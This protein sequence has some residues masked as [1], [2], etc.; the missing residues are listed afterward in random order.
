M[1]DEYTSETDANAIDREAQKIADD[2]EAL[3]M[4]H[5]RIQ[6]LYL[7]ESPMRAIYNTR[8]MV[9]YSRHPLDLPESML[10][11]A[12]V[13]RTQYLSLK[14]RVAKTL[15]MNEDGVQFMVSDY[16]TGIKAETDR[17]NVESW[18][19]GMHESMRELFPTIE[20][21][22]VDDLLVHSRTGVIVLPRVEA[23][24]GAPAPDFEKVNSLDDDAIDEIEREINQK[25]EERE[26]YIAAHSPFYWRHIPSEALIESRNVR[27][28]LHEVVIVEEMAC[29]DVLREWPN[30]ESNL[31]A[32]DR[33]VLT[34]DDTVTVVH[35][36]TD[37]ICEIAII[38]QQITR[39]E[40]DRQTSRTG[41]VM[42]EQMLY[43]DK[44]EMRCVPVA[45]A[46]GETNATRDPGKRFVGFFDNAISATWFLDNLITQAG[47]IVRGTAY[48]TPVV[49]KH[50]EAPLSQVGEEST[51]RVMELIEGAVND[52]LQRGETLKPFNMMDTGTFQTI[53]DLTQFIQNLVDMQTL[54]A[55][56]NGISGA[57]SGY[58]LGLEQAQVE[59]PL[60]HWQWGAQWLWVQVARLQLKAACVMMRAGLDPIPVRYVSS[61]GTQQ[62]KLT[63]DQAEKDWHFRTQVRIRQ[64]GGEMAMVQTLQAAEQA[65]YI[66]HFDAM[67]RFGVRNPSQKWEEIQIQQHANSPMIFQALDQALS[68]DTVAALTNPEVGQMQGAPI[69]PDS[70]AALIQTPGALARLPQGMGA[71]GATPTAGFGAQ[72][73]LP[74]MAGINM[75]PPPPTLSQGA[76]A[77]AAAG[78]PTGPTFGQGQASP[79]GIMRQ[80]AIA[81]A[82]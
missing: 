13:I 38:D 45:I 68:R 26:E 49:E 43:R 47:S 46:Y 41:S 79:G 17:S 25:R 48:P 39:V 3:A 12:A 24:K 60:L 9:L 65:G 74:N 71:M 37:T 54:P 51:P 44:H 58:Q 55:Q 78:M 22:I 56:A 42:S 14:R 30:A 2:A 53:K 40:G 62:V 82:T 75:A 35:R 28:G 10:E 77:Q 7:A 34:D 69:I 29:L 73:G 31:A 67:S 33:L 72:G 52:I 1:A 32:I 57:E 15:L 11:R 61:N 66:D 23:M 8:N 20:S 27:G 18:T 4:L 63:L 81:G 80:S 76:Q 59:R 70:L 5:D 64:V 21:D 16:G 50:I 36:L 6:A 19:Q